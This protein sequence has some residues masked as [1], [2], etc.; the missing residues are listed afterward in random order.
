MKVFLRGIASL[1]IRKRLNVKWNG[2]FF[3]SVL[4]Y[5][6]LDDLIRFYVKNELKRRVKQKSSEENSL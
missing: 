3:K 6:S 1:R 4:V 2:L 5:D